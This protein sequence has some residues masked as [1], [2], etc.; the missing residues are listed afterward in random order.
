MSQKK[1]KTLIC[2]GCGLVA[3][4]CVFIYTQSVR[5]SADNARADALAR[6]GGEQIEVCVATKDIAAGETIESTSFTTK[7]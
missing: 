3:A 7:M 5:I 6:Y 1:K 2:I 4:I